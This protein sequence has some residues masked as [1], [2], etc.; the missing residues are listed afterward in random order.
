M[1]LKV[2]KKVFVEQEIEITFPYYRKKF[3]AKT[4]IEYIKFFSN[5]NALS[6]AIDRNTG[7]FILLETVKH[8]LEKYDMEFFNN[9]HFCS[10]EEFNEAVNAAQELLD[11]MKLREK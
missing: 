3:Y 5:D 11:K 4:T 6:V 1:K 10:V 9:E 8:G 2:N 7:G